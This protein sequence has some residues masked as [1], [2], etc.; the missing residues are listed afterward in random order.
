MK[1]MT[2]WIPFKFKRQN[3]C[4]HKKYTV[5][6]E[7]EDNWVLYHWCIECGA[8]RPHGAGRWRA[9]KQALDIQ[10]FRGE[11]LDIKATHRRI[12]DEECSPDEKHCSCV[13]FLRAEIA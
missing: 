11:L 1:K 6:R 9:P 13:P 7:E 12:I 4:K 10:D 8:I 5:Y 2:Q 3:R